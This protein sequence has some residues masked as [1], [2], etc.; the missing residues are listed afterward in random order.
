MADGMRGTSDWRGKEEGKRVRRGERGEKEGEKKNTIKT[1]NNKNE[2][3][4]KTQKKKHLN[5]ENVTNA[6][7][8]NRRVLR[9]GDFCRF[10]E[11]LGLPLASLSDFT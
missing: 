9:Q 8:L 6:V 1:N 2:E 4:K 10:G 5:S 3:E 11:M 7:P